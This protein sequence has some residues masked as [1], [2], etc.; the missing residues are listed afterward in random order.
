M[1]LLHTETLHFEEFFDSQIPKY[2][3]LSHR[4]GEKEVSF[5]QM[6]KGRAPKGPGLTKIEGF[7]CLAAKNGYHWV[8]IDTCCIDKKSSAELSEAINSMFSWYVRAQECYVHLSDVSVSY[9]R[10][11]HGSARFE[12]EFTRSQWFT[13][14]WTLQELLAP[15][16]ISFYNLNW[17]FIGVKS[18]LLDEVS[19]ATNIEKRY[20]S[21]PGY[22]C[23]AQKM[24]WLSHRKTSRIEDMSYCMFGLFGIN[25]PLLYGEGERAFNRLQLEIL[26][27]STDESIFVF[28][29]EPAMHSRMAHAQPVLASFPA[30][31]C[32]SGNVRRSHPDTPRW[33][34][35]GL[36]PGTGALGER[37]PYSITNKDLKFRI[38]PHIAKPMLDSESA[39]LP[40]ACYRLMGEYSIEGCWLT[41]LEVDTD[42]WLKSYM[43]IEEL[44]VPGIPGK[45]PWKDPDHDD[46]SQFEGMK[47]PAIYLEIDS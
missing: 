33:E 38:P 31:F 34:R 25:L 45:K 42:V 36:K 9:E 1:R 13:R 15:R 28:D 39:K 41:I 23:V 32:E 24:S 30:Q 43:P 47:W 46:I 37:P 20:L 29:P 19:K 5:Q 22:A 44:Y 27:K 2:A 11:S 3:I 21:E 4:W 7:C 6:S 35:N 8:W 40:L 12:E 10:P 14:G 17:I 16:R 26:R 18:D